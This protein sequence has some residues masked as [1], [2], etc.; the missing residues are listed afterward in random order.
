MEDKDIIELFWNRDETAISE[1]DAK[2]GKLC[3]YIAG[4]ILAD[5]ED[6]AECVNDTYFGVWNAI[7]TQWPQRF[8]VFISRIS[9]NLAL[10]KY[11]YLSAAKRNPG[12]IGSLDEL[13]DCVSGAES[14]ETELEAQSINKA[15]NDFL[16]GLSKDKRT[17][18]LWRYWCFLSVAD[19][20]RRMNYS[21]SKVKSMLY[22]TRQALRVYL[23]KEGIY[24]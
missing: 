13:E 3:F 18:F 19:I 11:E 20:A 21:Q 2:Y 17:V 6:C 15:I 14:V 5:P 7:P 9:R 16:A 10:K 12:T 23:E 24:I 8:S 1:T 22:H 4:N